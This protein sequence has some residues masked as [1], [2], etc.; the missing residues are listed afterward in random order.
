MLPLGIV[1]HFRWLPSRVVGFLDGRRIEKL[2]VA[3]R[4]GGSFS[5]ASH[6][7]ERRWANRY[8]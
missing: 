2:G 5:G 6:L 8:A 4:R 7:K 1:L 3:A